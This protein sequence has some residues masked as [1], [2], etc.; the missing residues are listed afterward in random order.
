MSYETY[1]LVQDRVRAR[2]LEPITLK[3]ISREVVPYVIEGIY[4]DWPQTETDVLE[5]MS[6][7][8]HLRVDLT[9]LEKEEGKKIEAALEAALNEV[10]K[11]QMPGN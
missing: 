4:E 10:K 11:R 3:G 7:R 6:S 8:L 5:E 1:A 9:D 2:P